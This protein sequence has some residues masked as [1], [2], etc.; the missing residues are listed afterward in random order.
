MREGFVIILRLSRSTLKVLGHQAA[1]V[2][3]EMI[4]HERDIDDSERIEI[5]LTMKNGKTLGEPN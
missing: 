2:L 1:K 4:C 5:A 3:A